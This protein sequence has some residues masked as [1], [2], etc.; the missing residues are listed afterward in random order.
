MHFE[1]DLRMASGLLALILLGLPI[2]VILVL[3]LPE[4]PVNARVEKISQFDVGLV[5]TWRRL[6]RTRQ[7]KRASVSGVGG[8]L[9][10]AP[11]NAL[12]EIARG[13]TPRCSATPAAGLSPISHGLGR[14]G[15][16]PVKS[17]LPEGA[18]MP[19]Q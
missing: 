5:Y 9:V 4:V 7:C 13:G 19:G 10:L 14:G 11:A 3:L 6:S 1:S 15:G 17:L 8:G 16:C 2:G 12:E 18:A